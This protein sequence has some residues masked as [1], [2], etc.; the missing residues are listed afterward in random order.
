[1]LRLEFAR[2]NFQLSSVI[3][4]EQTEGDAEENRERKRFE[5]EREELQRRIHVGDI[6]AHIRMYAQMLLHK[7]WG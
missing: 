3:R 2:E 6:D 1:M 7:F 5:R 4:F